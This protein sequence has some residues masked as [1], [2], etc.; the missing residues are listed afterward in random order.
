MREYFEKIYK[1]TTEEFYNLVKENLINEKKTFVVTANPETIMIAEENK[2]LK[3]AV[4]STESIV[5]PDGIGIIKGAKMLG[6]NQIDKTITGIEF[7]KKLLEDCNKY[8]KSIFL[9]GAKK[10]VIDA[11]VNRIKKEYICIEIVGVE[12]GYVEDKQAVFDIIKQKNP[13][14]TLVALGIPNQEILIYNNLKDFDKGIFVGVGGS[15][16]VL[17]GTKKRAPKI[18]IKLN[19]EWLYRITK[20]PK[21]MKRFFNSN[22]KYVNKIRKERKR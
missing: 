7:V 2:I 9:F 15:F 8:K 14:V 6:Y 17:S 19:L 11:L 20:E 10:E 16:D 13:D 18:F 21:R 1:G 3:E 5:I 12:D 4:L 22:I